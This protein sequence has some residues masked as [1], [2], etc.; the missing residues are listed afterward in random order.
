MHA[1]HTHTCGCT[2]VFSLSLTPQIPVHE[3]ASHDPSSGVLKHWYTAEGS[4]GI[5]WLSPDG[6]R[7]GVRLP[8]KRQLLDKTGK[9]QMLAMSR[10]F[11]DSKLSTGETGLKDFEICPHTDGQR[12]P[13]ERFLMI[14]DI[15]KKESNAPYIYFSWIIW[16]KCLTRP[17]V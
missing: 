12:T 16:S 1:T 5:S 6:V 10:P 14:H 17:D 2:H 13:S 8:Q 11:L 7:V 4:L 15:H 3:L 9:G